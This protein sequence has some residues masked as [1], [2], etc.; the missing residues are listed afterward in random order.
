[1]MHVGLLVGLNSQRRP[2]EAGIAQDIGGEMH[3]VLGGI[4][5]ALVFSMV[6]GQARTADRRANQ[7]RCS[8]AARGARA[9]VLQAIAAQLRLRLRIEDA[10]GDVDFLRDELSVAM[11]E[12]ARLRADLNI[13]VAHVKENRAGRAAA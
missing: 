3:A 11:D 12:N 13:L 7:A 6:A 5:N 1:M 10:E 4:G 2:Q 9:D 8:A